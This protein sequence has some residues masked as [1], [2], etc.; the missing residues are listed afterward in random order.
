MFIIKMALK[1]L[2]LFFVC[3]SIIYLECYMLRNT[4]KDI[5][6]TKKIKKTISSNN[7]KK[8]EKKYLKIAK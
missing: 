1:I 3:V 4:V 2:F 8:N 6:N 7:K 5:K